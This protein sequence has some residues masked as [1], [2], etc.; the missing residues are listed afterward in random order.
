[1][2][3]DF[4]RPHCLNR[5]ACAAAKPTTH[6]RRCSILRVA[7]D[8]SLEAKRV[9]KLRAKHDDPQFAA[10]HRA[11]LRA[12]IARLSMDPA[13][14]ESRRRNGQRLQLDF[15]SRP[16]VVARNRSPEVRKAAGRKTSDTRLAW[17]PPHLRADYQVL[18]RS[19][20]LTAAEARRVIE[21]EIPGTVEHGRREVANNILAAQ[22]KHA[23]QKAQEY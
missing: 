10:E 13:F 22:I 19:K 7:S 20:L 2:V 6:C 5:G 18:I 4:Q 23:R 14:I 1:M 15:L 8:P 11:R 17:C 16:D 9:E 3:S 21:A 12:S